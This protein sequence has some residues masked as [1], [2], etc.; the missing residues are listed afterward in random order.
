MRNVRLLASL[1]LALCLGLW[2]AVGPAYAKTTLVVYT[3]L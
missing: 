2:Y 3:A 1:V